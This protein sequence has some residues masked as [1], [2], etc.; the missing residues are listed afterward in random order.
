MFWLLTAGRVENNMRILVTGAKGFIGTNLIIKL[1]SLNNID[2]DEYDMDNDLGSLYEYCS[3][4]DFV[5][6]LAGA[7]R[8]KDY[9][10]YTKSNVNFTLQLIQILKEYNNS[11][12]IMY[13][14]SIQALLDNPYGKSKKEAEDL[15]IQ[16]SKETGVKVLI[17]RLPNIFGKWCRPNYNSVIATFCYKNAH[18]EPITI[19]NP[20]TKL[21]LLYIDDLIEELIDS[22]SGKEKRVGDYCEVKEVYEVTLGKT[23]D[24]IRSFQHDR[25]RLL[26][27]DMSDAFTK[28]LYSTFLSYLPEQDLSYELKMNRDHRGSFTEFLK[29]AQMGQLS[30][31]ITKPGIVKG[32][33]WHNTKIEKFLVVSGK[34]IIRLRKITSDVVIN[35]YVS[36]EKFEV[37]DIPSGYTHNLENTGQSD[38]ITII[39]A[40]ESFDSNKPDTYYM[41]V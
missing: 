33:H 34:G 40:N 26:I 13:A 3:R 11:C 14:S 28:K 16:Y 1:K 31:N 20:D 2:I 23:A 19:D 24:L 15:L 9:A 7:N 30:V 21:T 29:Q 41:E 22:T 18:N 5:F 27:P 12:P 25:A 4:A 8:P 6:H 10:E 38:M 36:G 32:N 37:I 17:Y 39:W 35:Y